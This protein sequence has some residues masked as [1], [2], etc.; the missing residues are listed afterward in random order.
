MIFSAEIELI[1]ICS[2]LFPCT[3]GVVNRKQVR[4][5]FKISV[6]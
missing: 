6:S 5:A 3:V 4:I 2:V 1:L